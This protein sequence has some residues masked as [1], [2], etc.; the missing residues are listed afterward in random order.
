MKVKRIEQRKFTGAVDS[1]GP[2]E[3]AEKLATARAIE[4]IESRFTVTRRLTIPLVLLA[5]AALL[6]LPFLTLVPAALVSIVAAVITVTIGVAARPVIENAIAGL[7]ISFS[8]NFRFGDTVLLDGQYGTIEDIGITHT[9][10]K[11]WDWKRYII[12]NSQM[13]QSKILNFS[14]FDNFLWPHVEF[15]VSYDAD[16]ERVREIAIAAARQS[17][18]FAPYEEPRFWVMKTTQEG[19]QCWIAGWANGPANAWMLTHDIRTAL[20]LRFREEGIRAHRYD[21]SLTTNDAAA[22]RAALPSAE[23]ADHQ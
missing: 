22:L 2:I 3:D 13:L 23:S 16:L 14:L 7:T 15:W 10:L 4:S 1:D 12:P 6:S 5:T 19:V 20:A 9:T 18:Y 8:N 21:H 17:A 11:R